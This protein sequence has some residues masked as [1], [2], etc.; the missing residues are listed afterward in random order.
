MY[1]IISGFFLINREDG[2]ETREKNEGKDKTRISNI[3][4]E[5]NVDMIKQHNI[6]CE[7]L[8]AEFILSR[9]F[10]VFDCEK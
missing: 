5:C 7:L 3:V 2:I 10:L 6:V 9:C 4:F 8:S 1:L